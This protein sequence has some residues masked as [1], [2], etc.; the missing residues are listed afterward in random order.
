[1]RCAPRAPKHNDSF[2]FWDLIRLQMQLALLFG[3]S[4]VVASE[5][6]VA[7]GLVSRLECRACVPSR[8]PPS[9]LTLKAVGQR[10]DAA[11][12]QV[13]VFSILLPVFG[14]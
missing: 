3:A 9:L 8:G 5:A 14:F 1:M 10:P 12:L 2:F 4:L 6:F 11:L 7:P 13:N